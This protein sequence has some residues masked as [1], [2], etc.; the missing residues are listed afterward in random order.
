[1]FIS[2]EA[3]KS[4][5]SQYVEGLEL[6]LTAESCLCG[7]IVMQTAFG[8]RKV[9]TEV[10]LDC[11]VHTREGLILAFITEVLAKLPGNALIPADDW[12][13]TGINEVD[14]QIRIA[15]ATSL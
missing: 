14:P 1:M 3:V 5:I 10:N 6:N 9:K 15:D 7:W 11:P 4:L 2:R 8:E 12:K 13:P